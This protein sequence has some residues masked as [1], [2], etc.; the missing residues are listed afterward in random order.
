MNIEERFG[1]IEMQLE[2]LRDRIDYLEANQA[3]PESDTTEAC[4]KEHAAGPENRDL[5]ARWV[6]GWKAC[7]KSLLLNLEKLKRAEP[8][9]A[10]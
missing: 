3:T 4:I 1:V 6:N 9:D 7:A 2:V 5:H 8:Q 10:A